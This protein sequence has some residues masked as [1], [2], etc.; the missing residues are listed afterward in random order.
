MESLN[1]SLTIFALYFISIYFNE[2]S[3]SNANG[4]NLFERG[5]RLMIAVYSFEVSSSLFVLIL[6]FV[7]ID[8]MLRFVTD[9]AEYLHSVFFLDIFC[10]RYELMQGMCHFENL[11]SQ[12]FFLANSLPHLASFYNSRLF[13]HQIVNLHRSMNMHAASPKKKIIIRAA[14]PCLRH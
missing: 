11:N 12:V 6:L 4:R 8:F 7:C 3:N 2:L 1:G 14:I 5:E 13:L 10:A 9:M